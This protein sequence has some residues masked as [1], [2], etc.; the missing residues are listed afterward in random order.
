VVIFDFL[1]R[2]GAERF[3]ELLDETTGSHRH[4]AR[5]KADEQL[6]ELV[7]IGQ[8]LSAARTGNPVEPEFRTGLRAM[9]VATAERDGIGQHPDAD[10]GTSEQDTPGSVRSLLT[11]GSGRR[12][13]ARGAIVLGVAAGAMAVSG[14]SAASESAH[15]GDALYGVKRSTERAQLA[16]AGS[17]LT[18]GQLSLDFARNRV[19]EAGQLPGDDSEFGTVLNDMDNDTRQ[20]VR[21]LTGAAVSRTDK[22]PLSTVDAF[23]NAQRTRMIAVLDGLDPANQERAAESMSLLDKV[24]DRSDLLQTGLACGQSA[25]TT[26]DSLGPVLDDCVTGSGNSTTGLHEQGIGEKQGAK[27]ESGATPRTAKVKPDPNDPAVAPTPNGKA[28]APAGQVAPTAT[29]SHST[30][31]AADQGG[32]DSTDDTGGGNPMGGLLGGIFGH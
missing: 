6:A 31:P 9:L 23:V 25:P 14:I 13:R 8:S 3:A 5:G 2:R 7:A 17:D 21:L 16:M 20:G 4:H 18:R 27:S 30:D 29:S 26:T 15:P 22:A 19:A 24:A 11:R 12:I 28:K 32:A 10:A 1:D